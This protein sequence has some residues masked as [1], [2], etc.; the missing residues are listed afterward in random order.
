M[1]KNNMGQ[2][3]KYVKTGGICSQS[4]SEYY[5]WCLQ[6]CSVMSDSL[7]PHG[8]PASILCP[9]DSPGKNT[10]VGC[11]FLLQEVFPTQESNLCFLHFLHWQVDSLPTEPPGKPN[12]IQDKLSGNGL[13]HSREYK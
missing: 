6:A 12:M 2:I 11:H 9:R 10:G 13:A 3:T 5:L 8:L 1:K 7:Q 4:L